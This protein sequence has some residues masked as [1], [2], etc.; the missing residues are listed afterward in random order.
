MPAISSWSSG[1][2]PHPISVGMTGTPTNSANSTS[3]ALAS[4]LMIPPPATINGRSAAFSM[5]MACSACRRVA[6]GL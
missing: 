6:A 4:A 2:A 5:A 1:M 3:S